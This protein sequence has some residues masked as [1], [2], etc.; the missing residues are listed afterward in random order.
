VPGDADPDAGLAALHASDLYL[1]TACSDGDA[2][3]LA[4]FVAHILIRVGDFVAR[5]DRSAAFVDEV[6]QRLRERMRVARGG[7]PGICAYAGRGALASWVHVAALRTALDLRRSEGDVR[8]AG[9]DEPAWEQAGP[10][11]GYVRERYREDFRAAFRAALAALDAPA[12]RLLRMHFLDGLSLSQI[13]AVE[14]LDKSNVSRRLAA[15]RTQILQATRDRLL[16][17]LPLGV[18]ELDSLLGV[19][20]SQHDVSIEHLLLRSRA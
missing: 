4:A 2:G 7:R 16:A 19:M 5:V 12:R 8:E 18:D 20:R 6:R 9:D 15:I 17:K 3:A 1:A 11:L 13:G 14:R 10:E